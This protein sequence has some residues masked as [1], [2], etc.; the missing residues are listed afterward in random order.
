MAVNAQWTK[1]KNIA[2]I[3]KL[4]GFE[5]TKY[6]NPNLSSTGVPLFKGRNVQDSKVIYEFEGFIPLEISNKLWRSQVT[7]KCILTPYVGTIGNVGIH[8]KQGLFH[9]GSNVGK[10]EI[11]NNYS[12]NV[13][14]EYVFYYLKSY[15][16]YDELTQFKKATAQESISIDAI[17][18]TL[19]PIYPFETQ[20]NIVRK[21][22]IINQ[23]LD[24]VV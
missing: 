18:E 17:R 1:L 22:Q 2:F 12:L 24:S 16:G 20:K 10:I 15:T 3:T 21:L 11:Y 9:L 4:A 13:M 5:Y 19:I 23:L 8:D 6:V 14:E 7:R